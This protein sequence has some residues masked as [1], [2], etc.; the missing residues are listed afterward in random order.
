M[1]IARVFDAISQKSNHFYARLCV[2]VNGTCLLLRLQPFLGRRSA[3]TASPTHYLNRWMQRGYAPWEARAPS[4]TRPQGTGHS[5]RRA[6]AAQPHQPPKPNGAS[7]IWSNIASPGSL[8]LGPSDDQLPL[9][10]SDRPAPAPALSIAVCRA[11]STRPCSQL[12]PPTWAWPT[13]STQPGPLKLLVFT[14]FAVLLLR[15]RFTFFAVH[16]TAAQA[17]TC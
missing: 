5:Q 9:P 17:V 8:H 11:A 7:N 15:V 4:P 14:A 10:R 3:R 6:V 12:M 2:L 13:R 16:R 1:A